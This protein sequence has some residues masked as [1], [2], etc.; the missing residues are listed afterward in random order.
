[1]PCSGVTCSSVEFLSHRPPPLLLF[2]LLSPP[3]SAAITCLHC[4]R[5][6]TQRAHEWGPVCVYSR[7]PVA[8]SCHSER[9]LTLSRLFSCH[10]AGRSRFKLLRLTCLQVKISVLFFHSRW[11]CR[12]SEIR[13]EKLDESQSCNVF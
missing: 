9:T 2:P 7:A 13:S 5:L 4:S 6:I 10:F 1:M 12:R 3:P 8:F 11:F